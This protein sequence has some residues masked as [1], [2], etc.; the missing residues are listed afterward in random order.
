MILFTHNI[1]VK[2]T[3]DGS[4]VS[5]WVG[6]EREGSNGPTNGEPKPPI[7]LGRR[8]SHPMGGVACFVR[9][10][11]LPPPRQISETVSDSVSVSL[12]LSLLPSTVL[13]TQPKTHTREQ[14][15]GWLSLLLPS[16]SPVAVSQPPI[17]LLSLHFRLV[18]KCV[19]PSIPFPA[20]D[21]SANLQN[22]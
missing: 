5:I 8:Q 17:S 6:T 7:G 11:H 3:E 18:R 2:T 14:T 9:C 10:V 15:R 22:R 13:P 4:C 12:S 19:S 16:L 20:T 21:G 1:F